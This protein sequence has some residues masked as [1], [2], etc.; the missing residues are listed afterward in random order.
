MVRL[1]WVMS[2]EL[3]GGAH[4]GDHLGEAADV[5]FVERG[6]D[7]VEDAEGRGLELEDADEEREGGEGLFAAGEQ[8][9]V[10]QL[11]ARGRG[12][13]VDAG[14]SELGLSGSVRRMKAWPPPKSL[15]KVREK[16]SLMTL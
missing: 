4:V 5:G 14:E 3:G 1:L 7:F 13:D 15:V 8:Q 11:F 6:V 16:F 2:D 10:L 9:D 12:D